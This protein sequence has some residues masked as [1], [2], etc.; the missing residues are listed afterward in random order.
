MKN[1]K[2]LVGVALLGTVLGISNA[3]A[4]AFDSLFEAEV[5]SGYSHRQY[6][7]LDENFDRPI[8]QDYGS[9]DIID[10]YGP[11][12][13]D[14]LREQEVRNH[15]RNWSYCTAMKRIKNIHA[16]QDRS[17]TPHILDSYP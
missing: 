2:S 16:T 10:Y 12:D 7:A 15:M 17:S 5:S 8:F 9:L 11:C 4:I 6:P 1:F 13:H 14:P 3:P